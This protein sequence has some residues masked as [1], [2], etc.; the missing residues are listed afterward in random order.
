MQESVADLLR[1]RIIA[2]QFKPGERLIQDEIADLLGISRTPVR[3]ALQ[4]LAAEGF[5]TFSPH[6]GAFV[7]D[8]STN[9]LQEIYAVRIALESYAARLAAERITDAELLQLDALL[10]QMAQAREQASFSLLFELNRKFHMAIYA[11]ARQQRLFELIANYLELAQRYRLMFHRLENRAE[12]TVDE[13]QE[14]LTALRRHDAGAADRL[15]R[16]HLQQTQVAL[17]AAMEAHPLSRST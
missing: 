11:A 13:H 2:R 8:F 5:V 14:I 15:T 1:E 3:D 7:T 4:K 6:K 9:E 16:A 10:A 17:I 12:H